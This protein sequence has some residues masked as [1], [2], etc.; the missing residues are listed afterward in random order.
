MAVMAKETLA[1]SRRIFQNKPETILMS[2]FE[3]MIAPKSQERRIWVSH[4]NIFSKFVGFGLSV[5]VGNGT[6]RSGMFK[7]CQ[8]EPKN[9]ETGCQDADIC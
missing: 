5:G 9:F 4:K 7:I 1:Y 3:A 6:I 2:G 8:L